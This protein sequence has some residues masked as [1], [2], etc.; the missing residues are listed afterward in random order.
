MVVINIVLIY[1]MCRINQ[2]IKGLNARE[3]YRKEKVVF[4]HV[5][6]FSVYSVLWFIYQFIFIKYLTM[7]PD[8]EE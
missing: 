4:L 2:S 6:L 3:F 7:E 8:S 1:S 5:F